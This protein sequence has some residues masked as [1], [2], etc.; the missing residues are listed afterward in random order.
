[1]TD[2]KR[3]DWMVDWAWIWSRFFEAKR[4][5]ECGRKRKIRG[6]IYT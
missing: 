5:S 4:S 6:R 1:M 2:D 3:K